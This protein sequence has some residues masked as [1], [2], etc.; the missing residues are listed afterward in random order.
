MRQYR[1][2][3]CGLLIGY[4]KWGHEPHWFGMAL[5]EKR[6]CDRCVLECMKERGEDT[7]FFEKTIYVNPFQDILDETSGK[8][9]DRPKDR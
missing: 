4:K 1:C 7:S 6:M 9:D 3:R 5:P 2:K 8:S